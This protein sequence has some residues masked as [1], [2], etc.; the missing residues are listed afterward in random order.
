MEKWHKSSCVLCAQN[1][2]LEILVEDNKITRVKGDK[3][4]L[5]SKGYICRKGVNVA[6]HQHHDERLTHPLKKVDGEFVKISWDQAIEEIAE[7]LK[8][9]I[10]EHGPKSLA[11]MGGGGQGCHF[12][13]A[14][15]LG[16]LR[17]LGSRYHYSAIAQEFTGLFWTF[18]RLNG[19]QYLLYLPDEE[20]TEILLGIGWNGMVSHQ[21]PRA[22]LV[23]KEIA[24]NPDKKLVII[25]PRESETAK[26]AN[27]HLAI[28]PGTDALL[29]K[30]MIAII[31]EEGWQDQEYLKKHVN[32]FDQI[33]PWFKNFDYREAINLCE[34]DFITIKNLSQEICE[35]RTSIHPD[36][37]VYMSR[38]STVNSYLEYILMAISGNLCVKGGSII[39]GSV[40]PLGGHTDERDEKTWRTVETDFPAL[41]GYFPPN[42][43]PEEILSEKPDRLRAVL[44]SA[45]NPLRSYADTNAYEKAFNELD[46][47]VTCELAMTETAA[48][49]HYVLPAKSGY[50]SWDGTFF[51]LT[52]PEV[53]FQMRQPIVES[54]GEPKEVGEIYT[55]IAEKLGLIPA[56]PETLKEAAKGNRLQF[57]GALMNYAKDEPKVLKMMPFVLAKTLGKELGSGNLAALWGM[58][59]TAPKTFRD[60]AIRFG[61]NDS[62]I[63]GDKVFQ[64][65]ID[66]P[67]GLFLGKVDV[68][69]NFS[70]LKTEDKKIHVH[71][72][73]M[74]EWLKSIDAKSEKE[75]LDYNDDYPFILMAGRHMSMNANTL[76]RD[77]KWNEGK[78]AC[79]C[80]MHPKDADRLGFTDQQMVR[81][82][83]EAAH[84]DVE[85]EI[86]TDARKGQV[87]IPHGFGLNFNG[88]TYGVNVNRLTKNTHRDKFA[89]TPLHR[90]VPCKV[91]AV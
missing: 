48:L 49:S 84:V 66:Y 57:G 4:N 37:G 88:G 33:S 13:A 90:F 55:L 2:G 46:L 60:N 50:E 78:R 59:M 43:M 89:A 69:D 56:I 39:S 17:A 68:D 82:T 74:E 23:L 72:P 8:F 87:V 1:C 73:E 62:P 26:V 45:S 29:I 40:M 25:D 81:V 42:V 22:P 31:L 16:L 52:F 75:A 79:T 58:L 63:L 47:L 70:M 3:T 41:M 27:L 44:C 65:I 38:H 30:A 83:T 67:Q 21:M 91:E 18:G 85:L 53:F 9:I 24:K 6:S 19:K 77:P 28:R 86:T 54:E 71:I 76:M 10:G 34:L 15:G 35:K 20:N 14:F 11:Y 32:G 12:E 51:P 5:R 7:K 61:Y 36:L 80:A 64:D